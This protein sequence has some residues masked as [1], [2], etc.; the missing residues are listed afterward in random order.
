[1]RRLLVDACDNRGCHTLPVGGS[2]DTSSA[3]FEFSL[4]QSESVSGGGV[5][6][7]CSRFL[8]VDCPTVDPLCRD[9]TSEGDLTLPLESPSLHKS[10][11]SLVD[12]VKKLSTPGRASVAPFRASKLTHY[13]SEL[14]GGNAIVLATGLCITGQ[15]DHSRKTLELLGAFGAGV[16]YPVAGRELSDPLKGLL[17]KYRSMVIHMQDELEERERLRAVAQGGVQGVERKLLEV[18]EQLA[19]AT[20][21]RSEAVDD[22]A[23]IF[24]VAELL[25]AKYATLLTDHET[26]SNELQE[27][28]ALRLEGEKNLLD[29]KVELGQLKEAHEQ[30]LFGLSADILRLKEEAAA[31]EE[32]LT[33][34]QQALDTV[35]E[36]KNKLSE[37]GL[38]HQ[39]TEKDL[40]RQLEEQ[41]ALLRAEKERTVELGAELLTL[42]NRRELQLTEMEQL[43]KQYQEGL[44]TL[45]EEQQKKME[46]EEQ[47]ARSGERSKQLEEQ[48]L[49]AKREIAEQ[50]LEIRR[51]KLEAEEG[52]LQRKKGDSLYPG[53]DPLDPAEEQSAMKKL[54]R[55]LKRAES[56]LAE[57]RLEVRVLDEELGALRTKYREQL[58]A[59]MILPQPE[60][61]GAGLGSGSTPLPSTSEAGQVPAVTGETAAAAQRELM[62]TYAEH[63]TSNRRQ[64]DAALAQRASIKAAYRTLFDRYKETQNAAVDLLQS[65]QANA[66]AAGVKGKGKGPAFQPSQRTKQ[67]ENEL[68]EQLRFAN[69]VVSD[70]EAYL[71][72]VDAEDRSSFLWKS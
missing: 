26:L 55:Q 52:A 20:L 33:S 18:Q 68:E 66:T 1:M 23:R 61:T 31:K 59:R 47:L 57:S 13:L 54:S 39:E 62:R 24:E 30:E 49:T 60:V 27:E 3:V 48:L 2:I 43:Q 19:K 21:E 71:Q 16:H 69:K 50:D 28:K 72:M 10:L 67:L 32:Q 40:R 9:P 11:H 5:R 22:R 45:R 36:E 44:V 15:P 29:L 7:C 8:V 46:V 53:S 38:Q 25:R 4:F 65:L 51:V 58:S 56:D 64:L 35:I 37:V 63:E 70:E 17:A 42:V 12:V 14:L 34:V 41:Q 6:E